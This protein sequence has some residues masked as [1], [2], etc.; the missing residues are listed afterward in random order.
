MMDWK[1]RKAGDLYCSSACGRG[2]TFAEFTVALEAGTAL[3]DRLGEGWSP[4]VWENLGWHYKSVSPCGRIKVHPH[5]FGGRFV[6][7]LGEPSF[8]GGKWAEHGDSPR[9]AVNAVIAKARAEMD[10][11]AASIE[12]L[13]DIEEETD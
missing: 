13:V 4:E 5:S 3:A 10:D 9:E 2:C 1:P 6:A 11:I 12:G 8:P 7:F